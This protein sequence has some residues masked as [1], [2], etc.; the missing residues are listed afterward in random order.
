MSKFS[1]IWTHAKAASTKEQACYTSPRLSWLVTTL[2]WPFPRGDRPSEL[3]DTHNF[4]DSSASPNRW[5]GSFKNIQFSYKYA[6]MYVFLLSNVFQGK[7]EKLF[8]L[9]RKFLGWWKIIFIRPDSARFTHLWAL[10]RSLAFCSIFL[11]QQMG[12]FTHAA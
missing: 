4:P 12:S 6:C 3:Q 11:S 8:G 5:I 9:S 1:I 2:T 10:N 7:G